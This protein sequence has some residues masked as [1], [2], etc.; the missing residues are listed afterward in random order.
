M[1][2]LPELIHIIFR[3]SGDTQVE[4]LLVELVDTDKISE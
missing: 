4:C 3:T 1:D 2:A